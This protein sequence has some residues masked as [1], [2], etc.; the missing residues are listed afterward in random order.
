MELLA[1]F[2]V[3][4][5]LRRVDEQGV[6]QGAL[7][8]RDYDPNATPAGNGYLFYVFDRPGGTQLAQGVAQQL[9]QRASAELAM[10]AQPADGATITIDYPVRADE[11]VAITTQSYAY[12]F[13]DTP[14]AAQHVARGGSLAAAIDNLV[15]AINGSFD[16]AA[17]EV[18]YGTGSCDE[19]VAYRDDSTTM[20]LEA[21]D[22]GSWGNAVAVTTTVGNWVGAA[23]ATSTTLSGGTG[24]AGLNLH[25]DA[26]DLPASLIESPD[27]QRHAHAEIFGLTDTNEPIKLATCPVMMHASAVVL[28]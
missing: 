23:T 10:G 15:K 27:I 12:V 21:R 25:V 24:N 26:A 7:S 18:Y 3:P 5:Q 13:K 20:Q 17:P 2:N 1:D 14:T 19:L 4:V 16:Y 8:F 6:D 22:G 28:P 11:T 9:G